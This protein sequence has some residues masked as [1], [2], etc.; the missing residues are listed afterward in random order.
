MPWHVY[1]NNDPLE[2]FETPDLLQQALS[3]YLSTDI[4]IVKKMDYIERGT[5]VYG[6]LGGAL[7]LPPAPSLPVQ[8][9]VQAV[10]HVTKK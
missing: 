1:K 9:N 7:P 3:G 10:N 4:I 2:I 8:V 5:T 6:G